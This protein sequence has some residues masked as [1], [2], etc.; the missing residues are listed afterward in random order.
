MGSKFNY[1]LVGNVVLD[2]S[3]LLLIQRSIDSTFLLV[4]PIWMIDLVLCKGLSAVM[5]M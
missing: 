2:C 5:K 1:V 4:F 3:S